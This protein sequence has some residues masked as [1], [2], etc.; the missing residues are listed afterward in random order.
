VNLGKT[1]IKT[2]KNLFQGSIIGTLTG[3]ETVGAAI[4][5]VVGAVVG[6]G[7]ELTRREV[8]TADVIRI[9]RLAVVV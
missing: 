2:D 8:E 5:A 4:G 7:I 6:V 3:N 1:L 9:G